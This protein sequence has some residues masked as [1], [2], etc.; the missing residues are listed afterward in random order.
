MIKKTYL[1]LIA[2]ALWALSLINAWQETRHEAASFLQTETE[3]WKPQIESGLFK[4]DWTHIAV[5]SRVLVKEH[6]STLKITQKDQALF[7]Y[8]E[9]RQRNISCSMIVTQNITLSNG[10]TISLET[11]TSLSREMKQVASSAYF[12]IPL[13]MTA[14]SFAIWIFLPLFRH[15]QAMLQMTDALWSGIRSDL[16]EDRVNQEGLRQ[17]AQNSNDPLTA[18]FSNLFLSFAEN[19]VSLQKQVGELE[20]GQVVSELAAQ[21]AH[22]IRS[23]LSALNMAV[24]ALGPIEQEKRELIKNAIN[25]IN[26]IAN[27][28]LAQSKSAKSSASASTNATATPPCRNTNV[29]VLIPN[30]IEALVREKQIRLGKNSRIL[31]STD[32][33][34]SRG[35]IV[36]A[37]PTEVSRAL[38]NL[39]ENAIEAVEGMGRVHIRI[40]RDILGKVVISI[41]DN[42]KGIPAEALSR[43]GEKGFTYGKSQQSGNGLGIYHAIKT[44]NSLGGKF[45][46]QSQIGKGTLI[47]LTLP[48]KTSGSLKHG[49]LKQERLK[50]NAPTQAAGAIA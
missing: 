13:L 26:N 6:F 8:P 31:I 41:Q 36:L 1:I 17:L 28:L 19:Q 5:F 35:A 7:T 50:Q 45:S 44:V 14:L 15:H 34:Q 9:S 37:N 11:C 10:Q 39:V 33:R 30:L 18:Q 22:D 40:D 43:I 48:S 27:D 25:R 20:K 29:P 47:T 4:N 3:L 46:I 23:P 21:V 49:A 2:I 42:G 24:A 16:S 12:I 38:S 32:S